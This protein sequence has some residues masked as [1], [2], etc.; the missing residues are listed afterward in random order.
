MSLRKELGKISSVSFGFG[1]YQDCMLGLS[2]TFSMKGAS[3]S[4]FINGGWVAERSDQASWSEA[5]RSEQQSKMCWEI[6]RLLEKA[7]VSDV[8]DLE[9]IPVEL[10]FEGIGLLEWRILEEVL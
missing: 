10:T 6:I 5:D 3:V 2:M 8:R 4:T 9:G 7:K 1:G